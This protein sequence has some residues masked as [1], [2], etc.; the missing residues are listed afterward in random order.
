MPQPLQTSYPSPSM[1]A[2][3]P[4]CPQQGAIVN[5]VISTCHYKLGQNTLQERSLFLQLDGSAH[6]SLGT[7]SM[8]VT[9]TTAGPANGV[10]VHAYVGVHL[11]VCVH[12]Y[13][14]VCACAYMC[15]SVCT[16]VHVHICM[17]V[18]APACMCMCAHVTSTLQEASRLAWLL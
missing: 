16:H 12:E 13:M 2:C 14:H 9:V 17:P 7:V 18:C 3:L 5:V 4:A 15:V 1:K 10:L 11:C 6:R 8:C